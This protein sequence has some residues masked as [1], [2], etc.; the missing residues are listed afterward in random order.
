M[1]EFTYK[2][3]NL[4]NHKVFGAT[5]I[6]RSDITFSQDDQYIILHLKRSKTDIKYTVV[7]II[8]T[9]TNNVSC[10]VSALCPL[11]M[12]DLQ[13]SNAPLF[14]LDNRAA[15]ACKLV[16]QIFCHKLEVSGILYQAYSDHSFCKGA[17]QHA[18]DNGMLDEHIQILDW[19]SLQAF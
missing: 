14:K 8:I 13:P 10:P 18:S 1:G 2:K 5:K 9:T 7:E 3:A 11:F 6:T 15:F 4:E 19:W 17:A 16:I 12:V